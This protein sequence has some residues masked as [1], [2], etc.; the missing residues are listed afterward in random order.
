MEF[1]AEI[2]PLI[3]VSTSKWNKPKLVQRGTDSRCEST[4]STSRCWTFSSVVSQSGTWCLLNS[5]MDI[6]IHKMTAGPVGLLFIY[7]LINAQSVVAIIAVASLFSCP[8]RIKKC[9]N[10]SRYHQVGV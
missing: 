6:V 8:V 1:N 9:T 2:K 10:Q 7:N 3:G 5:L 4:L